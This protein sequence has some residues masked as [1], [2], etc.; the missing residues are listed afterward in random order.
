LYV[1][2]IRHDRL[3]GAAASAILTI[4]AV[5]FVFVTGAAVSYIFQG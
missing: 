4:A 3:E 2:R 1:S 5:W